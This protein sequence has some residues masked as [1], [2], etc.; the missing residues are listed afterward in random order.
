MPNVR[1]EAASAEDS[2]V[3]HPNL[4]GMGQAVA[5]GDA[6]EANRALAGHVAKT[7]PE[8]CTLNTS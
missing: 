4:T 8:G 3:R 6:K 7:Q 5:C 2:R 1:F